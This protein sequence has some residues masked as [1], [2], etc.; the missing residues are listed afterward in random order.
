MCRRM[1]GSE[2]LGR[3]EKKLHNLCPRG[4]TT[5]GDIGKKCV[6]NCRADCVHD[7]N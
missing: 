2:W 6:P 3:G 5:S 7:E 1:L 4:A